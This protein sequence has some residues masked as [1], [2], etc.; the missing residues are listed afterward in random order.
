MVNEKIAKMAGSD[1]PLERARAMDML[2]GALGASPH[3]IEL[4]LKGTYDG[5]SDV[6]IHALFGL[7]DIG[8]CGW[9]VCDRARELAEGGKQPKAVKESAGR[10]L[11]D[12]EK[13]MDG[14][15]KMLADNPSVN[16]KV[17]AMGA[18]ADGGC[19]EARS[20]I[21]KFLDSEDA[22]LS[23]AAE[24]ALEMLNDVAAQRGRMLT[25]TGKMT[26]RIAPGELQRRK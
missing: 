7:R 4:L 8:A 1:D 15:V 6:V 18:L 12:I 19:L 9:K 2:G 25:A 10:L 17:A 22:K 16:V 14:N 26:S 3:K 24:R 13:A 20:S 11:E 23:S 21:G 5:D